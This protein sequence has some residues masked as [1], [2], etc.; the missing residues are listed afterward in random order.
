MCSCVQFSN[1]NKKELTIQMG[2]CIHPLLKLDYQILAQEPR[3]LHL[4]KNGSAQENIVS[5]RN[6]TYVTKN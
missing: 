2:T 5:G 4:A 1:E 6:W 3:F